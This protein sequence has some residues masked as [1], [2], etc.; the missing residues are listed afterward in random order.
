MPPL[1][2]GGDAPNTSA[3]YTNYSSRSIF[4]SFSINKLESQKTK[5]NFNNENCCQ[6]AVFAL[7]TRWIEIW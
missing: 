2:Y 7:R 1:I 5:I 4:F 3:G 6:N